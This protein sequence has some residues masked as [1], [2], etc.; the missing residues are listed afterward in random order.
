MFVPTVIGVDETQE[1]KEK[2]ES[3]KQK[4]YRRFFGEIL[5]QFKEE[6][7]DVTSKSAG[8]DNWIPIPAGHSDV[9]FAWHFK[10][11]P[12][13]KELHVVMNFQFDDR[14]RNKEMLE[15]IWQQSKTAPW[16][17]LMRSTPRSMETAGT[18]VSTSNVRSVD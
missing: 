5:E 17:C 7:P 13:D 1:I 9:G 15:T 12:V 3:P 4:K 8:S 11:D 18:R 14:E 16:T 2:E 10:G 6:L